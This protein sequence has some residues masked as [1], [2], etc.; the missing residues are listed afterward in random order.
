MD[1]T[2]GALWWYSTTTPAPWVPSP[3]SA[4]LEWASVVHSLPRVRSVEAMWCTSV[5]L[6]TRMQMPGMGAFLTIYYRVMLPPQVH[7]P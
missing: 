6:H 4:A 1:F 5:P 3:G 7:L 2:N